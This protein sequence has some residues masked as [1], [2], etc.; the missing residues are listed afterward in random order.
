ML[1]PWFQSLT[2]SNPQLWREC[3]SRLTKRNVLV[4]VAL[5]LFCQGVSL[6][7]FWRKVFSVV[8]ILE[9][10]QAGGDVIADIL[11][12]MWF[13]VFQT[14]NGLAFFLL[15]VLGSYLLVRDIA[16]ED[17]RG[18][19]AFL[20]LSPESSHRILLGKVVGVPVLLY[21]AIAL[22][23]PL[24]WWAAIHAGLSVFPVFGIYLLILAGCA[25]FYSFVMLY[26]V[27][28]G[29]RARAWYLVLPALIVNF[30]LTSTGGAW[31]NGYRQ[32]L[33]TAISHDASGILLSPLILFMLGAITIQLWQMAIH[34]FRHPPL[35]R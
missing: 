14:L 24:H 7:F 29:A 27:G 17:R 16:W 30:V 21:V 23:L 34:F 22:V 3:R 18:T 1:L 4:T 5:S 15:L 26:A 13:S 11:R 9:R 33:R 8:S 35:H 20:R 28:W 19:L 32:G 6:L 10:Q 12:T 31:L 25:C 2:E